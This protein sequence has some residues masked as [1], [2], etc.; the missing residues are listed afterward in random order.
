M[1]KSKSFFC[2]ARAAGKNFINL[3][4]D[5]DDE[6]IVRNDAVAVDPL[7][8][9]ESGVAGEGALVGLRQMFEEAGRR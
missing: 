1:P 7:A 9:I 8:A 2:A 3:L 4:S 5:G 6:R